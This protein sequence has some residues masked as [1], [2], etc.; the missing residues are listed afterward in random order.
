MLQDDL[1]ALMSRF[2]SQGLIKAGDLLLKPDAALRLVDE[3]EQMGVPIMG[4][5][6]WCYTEVDART[7]LS[8]ANM[9]GLE[10]DKA[11]LN[12]SRAVKDGAIQARKFITEN[13]PPNTIF[14]S[15]N[16]HIPYTWKLFPDE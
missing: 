16:L 12:S 14:V 11:T 2:R 1:V 8:Q 10:I 5:D 4:V 7:T 13:L 9:V 15:L 6:C 3:V